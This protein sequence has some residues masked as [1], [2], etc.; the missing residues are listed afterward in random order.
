MK[1]RALSLISVHRVRNEVDRVGERTIVR[2]VR[3]SR[4][5]E[6]SVVGRHVAGILKSADGGG[7][8]IGKAREVAG[9][10]WL[11]LRGLA[12]VRRIGVVVEA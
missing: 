11:R 12:I 8:V 3:A 2:R 1:G 7:V 5:Q 9:S 10:I 6:R 4:V